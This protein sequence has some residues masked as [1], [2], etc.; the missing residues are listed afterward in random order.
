MEW[1]AH[2]ATFEPQEWAQ[3][4]DLIFQQTT[5]HTGPMSFALMENG[6][7]VLIKHHPFK[8]VVSVIRVQ[9]P[10]VQWG[11]FSQLPLGQC[12]LR[13]RHLRRQRQPAL[14]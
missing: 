6:G 2:Q 13:P 12:L 8:G 4:A 5:A 14:R 10:D 3:E 9:T 1:V 7:L 11:T